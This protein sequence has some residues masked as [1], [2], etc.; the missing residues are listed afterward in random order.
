MRVGIW[1][2]RERREARRREVRLGELEAI[3]RAIKVCPREMLE[4][5]VNVSDGGLATSPE[6]VRMAF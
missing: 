4:V 2:E 5:G 6:S 3:A 1:T